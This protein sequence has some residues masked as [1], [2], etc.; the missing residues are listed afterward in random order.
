MII[1]ICEASLR[2]EP[3]KK[4]KLGYVYII[5]FNFC[6]FLQSRTVFIEYLILKIL[7]DNC[8]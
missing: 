1:I 6:N 4:K 3:K 2:K 7:G 8:F 5:F